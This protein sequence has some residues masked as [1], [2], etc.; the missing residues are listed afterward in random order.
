MCTLQPL[1]I[2]ASFIVHVFCI[3][4][5]YNFANFVVD[6]IWFSSWFFLHFSTQFNPSK[7]NPLRLK[8]S[9]S[10]VHVTQPGS[11]SCQPAKLSLH[12]LRRQKWLTGFFRL[13]WRYINTVHVIFGQSKRRKKAILNGKRRTHLIMYYII[14][15]CIVLYCIV[16]Y[17]IV[18]YCIVLYWW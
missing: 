16:L 11:R 10:T 13:I 14:L 5:L 3:S 12:F 17:C 8:V 1:T 15:H 6:L 9:K 7:S 4:A 2:D 18:L